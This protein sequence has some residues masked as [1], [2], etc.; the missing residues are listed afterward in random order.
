MQDR[1]Q[2]RRIDPRVVH[3]QRLQ[4]RVAVLLDHENLR[5]RLHE[6]EDLVLERERAQAQGVHVDPLP[7]ERVERLR[8]R[9][10]G[11]AVVNRA[12]ARRLLGRAEDGLGH[13]RLRRLELLQQA[14]H[15]GLVIR[16]LLRVDRV[17]VLGSPAG[18][19]AA[20]RGVRARI[21]AER[22]PVAVHVEIPSEF[23]SRV[24]HLGRHHLAA[25]VL[26]AVVPLKRRAQALVHADVEIAHQEHRR[27]QPLGEVERLRGHLE[28][29]VRVLREKQHVLGVAVARVG[30]GEDVGLLRARRHARRRPAALHVDDRHRNLG[31]IR[32]PDEFLHERDAG[33][34]GRGK[35]ARAVPPRPDGDAHRSELVLA[36]HDGELVLAGF[37][38]H[39]QLRAVLLKGFG[40]RRGRRDRVPGAHRRPAVDAA[41][42]RG[43]VALDE[44]LVAHDIGL[45]FQGP[46]ADAQGAFQV[47]E[48]IGAPELQRVQVGLQERFLALV[49][50]ADQLGDHQRVDAEQRRER[51]DVDDVLEELALARVGVRLVADLGQRQPD[52]VDVVA[53]LGLRQRLGVVVE[54]IAA[55]VDL[56]HV[57]VPGLRVHRHHEIDAAAAT[58]PARLRDAHL[59]PG[60]QALDVRGEYVAR[61]DRNAHPQDSF[62]EELVRRGR[63]RAVHVRELDDEGVDRFDALGHGRSIRPLLF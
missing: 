9:G 18:E 60:G 2:A 32:E 24:E 19:V 43:G 30:A 31:E 36:L 44:D 57:G 6:I 15:V 22:N 7:R 34:G 38:V 23:F 54:K 16:A 21:G 62:G 56:L 17:G 10:T 20:L 35:G 51:P 50:L 45:A 47:L 28:A 29:L 41:E 27:L 42:R 33:A 13:Q 4:L 1:D 14:L 37:L 8:H 59:V 55:R 25:V 46:H 11:R 61:A 40:E 48:R 63:A 39:S 5:V 53:E 12:E 58:E 52:D 26:A 49:L 3:E